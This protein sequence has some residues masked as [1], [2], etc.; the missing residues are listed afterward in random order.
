MP[1]AIAAI[2]RRTPIIGLSS[3]L[4]RA[5]GMTRLISPALSKVERADIPLDSKT[6]SLSLVAA[7]ADLKLDDERIFTISIPS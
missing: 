6:L 2:A 1:V 4:G 5:R 7:S 3:C